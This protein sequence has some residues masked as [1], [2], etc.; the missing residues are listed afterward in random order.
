MIPFMR[1][2][3]STSLQLF[4][5]VFLA[6]WIILS[7]NTAPSVTY[8]DSG[9]LALAA[10][11]A[12]IPH[13]PGMPTWTILASIFIRLGQFDDPARGTNLFSAFCGAGTLALLSLLALR[14]LPHSVTKPSS[15]ISAAIAAPLLL[16]HSPAFLEQCFMTEQY[17]LM[18]AFLAGILFYGFTTIEQDN[19]GTPT[20]HK[21]G[22]LGLLWGLAVGNHMS[23]IALA[24]LMVFWI[25]GIKFSTRE[26]PYVARRSGYLLAGFLLGFMVYL[27]IPLRSG[28]EPLMDWGAIRSWDRL[29]WALGRKSWTHRD[30]AD[31]PSGFTSVW[32]ESFDPVAQLGMIGIILTIAGAM[33]LARRH[34][35]ILLGLALATL[36]YAFGL[37]WGHLHEAGKSIAYLRL[38]GV[39]DWHLPLYLAAALIGASAIEFLAEFA[40]RKINPRHSILIPIAISLVLTIPALL[41][42]KHSSMRNDDSASKFIRDLRVAMP[43]DAVALPTG[44]N[45]AFMLTFDRHGLRPHA[46]DEAYFGIRS[47]SDFLGDTL[48]QKGSW[49]PDDRVRYLTQ[50]IVHPQIQPLRVPAI[51]PTRAAAIPIFTDYITSRSE[52]APYFVPAG[53]LFQFQDRPRSRDEIIEIE[54]LNQLS[55]PELFSPPRATPNRF[56]AES[57]QMMHQNR[58][59]YFAQLQLWEQSARAYELATQWHPGASQSW[60]SLGDVLFQLGRKSEASSAYIKAIQA[61][62]YQPFARN[63]LA[64]LQ[65]QAGDRLAALELFREEVRLFPKNEDARKNLARLE[66]VLAK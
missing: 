28:A 4:V 49:H 51:P 30:A 47:L 6:S 24:P 25:I 42:I 33:I 26:L 39:T 63:N 37:Y 52:L 66:G 3:R 45:L 22:L 41:S 57:R 64:L 54:I 53:L 29:M 19:P 5:G 11:S 9:E 20:W 58:A 23:Q 21:W 17:T 62:F 1:Y 48:A 40:T 8:H 60:Q 15:T 18:T 35:S 10:A 50:V 14:V 46:T 61:D 44:D 7:W 36:P 31:A 13:P 12:G 59:V 38:Y 56:E 55:H 16:L 34:K 27:W 43:P 32:I 65:V 2:L